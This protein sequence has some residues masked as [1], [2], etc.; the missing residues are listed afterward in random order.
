MNINFEVYDPHNT[1]LKSF[2][3]SNLDTYSLNAAGD[4]DYKI[5]LYS[6]S[7]QK[8]VF[9]EV[10]AHDAAVGTDDARDV[11]AYDYDGDYFQTDDLEAM[12]KMD[13]E[14]VKEQ[15]DTTVKVIKE[16]HVVPVGA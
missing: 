12:R 1:L 5:C 7:G 14:M 11:Y 2:V 4:G 9:I 3:D 16:S 10:T 13:K 6:Y 15:F 8:T